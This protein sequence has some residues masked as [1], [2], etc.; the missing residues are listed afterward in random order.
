MRFTAF[1]LVKRSIIMTVNS[2][3]DFLSSP[4]LEFSGRLFYMCEQKDYGYAYKI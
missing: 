3:A 1:R 2:P 4:Y